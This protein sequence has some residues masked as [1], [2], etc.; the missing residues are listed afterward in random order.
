MKNLLVVWL[1]RCVSSSLLY[2]YVILEIFGFFSMT[3]YLYTS[4]KKRVRT[5][6][7]NLEILFFVNTTY[8]IKLIT[9]TYDKNPSTN[10]VYT[11][12]RIFTDLFSSLQNQDIRFCPYAGEYKSVKTPI[13]AYFM[14]CNTV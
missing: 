6:R 12:I 1:R 14:Q 9:T 13:L 2:F 11:R 7:Q 8:D 3:S 5:E 10:T 4:D